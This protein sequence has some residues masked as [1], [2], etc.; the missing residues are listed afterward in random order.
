MNLIFQE[1]TSSLSYQLTEAL[2]SNN[3]LVTWSSD[4][5]LIEMKAKR[6][7]K[8]NDEWF[9]FSHVDELIDILSSL[10]E[11]FRNLEGSLPVLLPESNNFAVVV[12]HGGEASIIV[13]QIPPVMSSHS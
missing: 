12:H 7:V 8:I 5:C 9:R 6:I 2:L 1:I 13:D 3:E 4:P 11:E 10:L